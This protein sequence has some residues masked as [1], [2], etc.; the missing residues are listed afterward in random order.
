MRRVKCADRLYVCSFSPS[1]S[2]LKRR[3][4]FAEFRLRMLREMLENGEISKEEFER[5]YREWALI[6]RRLRIV[7]NHLES[8]KKEV[9][10]DEVFGNGKK[11]S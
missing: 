2:E 1:I 3:L 11:G 10:W 9:S 8:G 7:L 6:S 4:G 5:L